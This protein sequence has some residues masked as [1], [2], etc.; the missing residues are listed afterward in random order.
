MGCFFESSS[1][2]VIKDKNVWFEGTV[3]QKANERKMKSKKQNKQ[4]KTD[5]QTLKTF[6]SLQVSKLL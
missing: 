4:P 3:K 2:P 5:N 1:L 6:F